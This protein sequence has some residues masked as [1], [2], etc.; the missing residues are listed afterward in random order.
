MSNQSLHLYIQVA[1]I[2][3]FDLLNKPPELRQPAFDA[4]VDVV[5]QPTNRLDT[6]ALMDATRHQDLKGKDIEGMLQVWDIHERGLFEKVETELTGAEAT[7]WRQTREAFNK[8]VGGSLEPAGLIRFR[9]SRTAE[10]ADAETRINALCISPEAM[11]LVRVMKSIT[12]PTNGVVLPLS[13]SSCIEFINTSISVDTTNK[14][15]L[16]MRMRDSD[17]QLLLDPNISARMKKKI[18]SD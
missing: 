13:L 6:I 11:N 14:W 5:I 8:N 10:Q 12:I 7:V 15:M 16:R 18:A 2:L 4:L 3:R 17:K 9:D 1:L